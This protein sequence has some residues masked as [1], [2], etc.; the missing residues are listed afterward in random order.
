MVNAGK[1]DHIAIIIDNY[2][3]TCAIYGEVLAGFGYWE[4]G[5]RAVQA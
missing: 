1:C 5:Q 3:E 2:G 4:K